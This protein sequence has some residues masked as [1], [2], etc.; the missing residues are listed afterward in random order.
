MQKQS[1]KKV[2]LYTP[3]SKDKKLDHEMIKNEIK[4]FFENKDDFLD[5]STNIIIGNSKKKK[6]T[7][8]FPITS[9]PILNNSTNKKLSSFTPL[10]MNKKISDKKSNSVSFQKK[11]EED[12]NIVSED[13]L[14]KYFMEIKKNNLNNK[15]KKKS[16]NSLNDIPLNVKNNLIK[17]EN[18]LKTLEHHN[19]LTRN[20]SDV[21]KKKTKKKENELLINRSEEFNIKKIYY[22]EIEK[23]TPKEEILGKNIWFSSL[24]NNNL[25]SQKAFLYK[26]QINLNKRIKYFTNSNKNFIHKNNSTSN[27]LSKNNLLDKINFQNLEIKGQNLFDFEY[28][29]AIQPGKKKLYKKYYLDKSKLKDKFK[30]NKMIYNINFINDY[31]DKK[32]LNKKSFDMNQSQEIKSINSSTLN[33]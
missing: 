29:L 2:Y 17:Q 8:I 25:L 26:K 32:K 15:Y 24:R 33:I 31:K 18:S 22:D 9:L 3:L 12:Y 11:K 14:K 21:I 30:F 4:N 23:K 1:N 27:L 5:I 7:I 6:Y 20:I 19:L 10:N 28:N 16:N 13:M